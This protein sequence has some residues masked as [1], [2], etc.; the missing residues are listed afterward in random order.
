MQQVSDLYLRLIAER[1]HWFETRLEIGDPGVILTEIGEP[2]TFGDDETK[3]LTASSGP[4][5]GFSE[6]QLYE[7]SI[8]RKVFSNDVP[9]V[10][11]CVAGQI[12]VRMRKTLSLN[13][14]R[15]A[16]LVPWV[17]VTNGTEYSE[18][19]QK[20]VFYID[21]REYTNTSDNVIVTLHGYDAML[22]AE[23]PFPSVTEGLGWPARDWKVVRLIAQTMGV[24]V[25]PRTWDIITSYGIQNQ[26][27]KVQ[28]P[29][30]YTLREV[31]GYIGAMY[32][33]NWVMTDTGALRLIALNE[34]PPE[35]NYLTDQAGQNITFDDVNKVYDE[36]G[37]VRIRV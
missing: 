20:G 2:I 8:T 34:L 1:N 17:R 5:A 13:I 4:G 26:G 11:C 31:L 12:D 33:G 27:Y 18:W 25:D 14:P 28:L 21:T 16:R 15:M 6:A 30:F 36:E 32:A 22:K 23:Q 19:L 3:I 10:G 29:A 35:T 24:S 7:M 9:E 37:L